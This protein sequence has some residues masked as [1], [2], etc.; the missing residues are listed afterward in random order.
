M[1]NGWGDFS[2]IVRIGVVNAEDAGVPIRGQP[3]IVWVCLIRDHDVASVGI[4]VDDVL[5][6]THIIG[7]V[8]DTHDFVR[9]YPMV[10]DAYT[11]WIK[12]GLE[13]VIFGG[14]PL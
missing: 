2:G 3:P 5:V 4:Q 13:V 14:E 10:P 11:G 9:E 8:L 1:G 7:G 12:L 6:P